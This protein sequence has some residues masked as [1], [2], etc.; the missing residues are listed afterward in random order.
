MYRINGEGGIIMTLTLPS[1]LLMI[2]ICYLNEKA[3]KKVLIH[4]NQVYE[5][6]AS[7]EKLID[8]LPNQIIILSAKNL[9]IKFINSK[10]KNFFEIDEENLTSLSNTLATIKHSEDERLDLVSMCKNSLNTSLSINEENNKEFINFNAVLSSNSTNPTFF[11]VK[12]GKLQWRNEKILLIILN[13][14]SS[15]IQFLKELNEYKDLLLASVSHDLRTPLNCIMGILEILNEE[16]NDCK[17]LQFVDTAQSSSKMLLSLI[18]DILDYRLLSNNKLKLKSELF[19]LNDMINELS[20]VF[21]YQAKRKKLEFQTIVPS[22]LKNRKILGDKIRLEQIFINLIGNA[23]KFTIKGKIILS[24]MLDKCPLHD[25]NVITFTVSD[26]GIGIGGSNIHEIFNIFKKIDQEN[27]NINPTGVGLGLF[28]SQKLAKNMHEGGITVVSEKNKGSKFC[29]SLPVGES[30]ESGE[31]TDFDQ[32]DSCNNF[33]MQEETISEKHDEKNMT[34]KSI[35]GF[36]SSND[37]KELNFFRNRRLYVLF[38]DD[39]VMNIFIYEKYAESLG[40]DYQ[41][42]YNGIEL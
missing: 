9:S 18:N 30:S 28:L 31:N 10:T 15:K 5:N 34:I 1:S 25:E 32:S 39:D 38:V 35:H 26:T 42:A 13:D 36:N 37:E 3:Y 16:I 29:F 22:N 27:P 8:N 20:G 40:M 6:I 24:L 33:C 12:I 11:D 14:I 17:L 21:D 23:L 2:L 4:L 7:F 19:K 41:V